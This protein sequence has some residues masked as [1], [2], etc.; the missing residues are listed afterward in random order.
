VIVA[1]TWL[2]GNMAIHTNPAT[3]VYIDAS[4]AESP[5]FAP[6]TALRCGALV[7]FSDTGRGPATPA[8][9]AL[10]DAAPW[11]GVDD[12]RWGP[13]GPMIDLHWAV[14]PAGPDCLQPA[15]R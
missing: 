6:G 5:W 1:N 10:Y 7:A 12:V 2:G 14:I 4:D 11:K 13:K 3:Q 9:R 15:P 8:V